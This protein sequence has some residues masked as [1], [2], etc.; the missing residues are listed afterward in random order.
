MMVCDL[1]ACILAMP[2]CHAPGIKITPI[3]PTVLERGSLGIPPIPKPEL[4]VMSPPW[5]CQCWGPTGGLEP[6]DR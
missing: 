5:I 6:L 4:R 2:K 1:M 3:F